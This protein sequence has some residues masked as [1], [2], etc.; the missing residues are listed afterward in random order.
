MASKHYET[1]PQFMKDYI[2]LIVKLHVFQRQYPITR[3]WFKF[4]S[5]DKTNE[6]VSNALGQKM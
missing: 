6:F 3:K 5:I 2:T 1:E 4:M